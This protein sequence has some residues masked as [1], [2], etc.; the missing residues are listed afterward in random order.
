MGGVGATLAEHA[1][2]HLF[3]ECLG[4]DRL[5]GSIT[6]T[7]NGTT[8]QLTAIAQKRGFTV[9][10]GSAHRTVL[11]NR[12]LLREIQRQVRR[13]YHEHLII[14]SSETPRKQV[15]QWVIEQAGRRGQ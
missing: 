8:L 5:R 2:E 12:R 1:F 9:L 11:A 15:W 4:W 6:A 14:Y 3:I 13:T 10:H 7:W